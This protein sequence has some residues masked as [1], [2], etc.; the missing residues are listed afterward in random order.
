MTRLELYEAL[1]PIVKL[2]TGVPITILANDNHGAPSG[3]YCSIE[4]FSDIGERGQANQSY[5]P[6]GALD[7]DV[8]IKPQSVVQVSLNF[9]RDD[10]KLYASR[11]KQCNKRPDVQ[12]LLRVA[13]IGWNNTSNVRDLTSLQSGLYEQR[14]QISVTLWYEESFDTITINAINE[15]PFEIIYP[16]EIPVVEFVFLGSGRT[17]GDGITLKPFRN[18][19]TTTIVETGVVN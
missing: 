17:L 19:P 2:A 4:P 9:Y 7:V 3:S 8:T 15:V 12:A 5:T 14:A 10:A 18:L 11:L 16:I 6:N 1:Y 13:G